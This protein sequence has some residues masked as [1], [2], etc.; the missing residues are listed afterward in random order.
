MPTA[1]PNTAE[2]APNLGSCELAISLLAKDE[3][4]PLPVDDSYLLVDLRSRP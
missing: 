3:T 2:T 4:D 1:L